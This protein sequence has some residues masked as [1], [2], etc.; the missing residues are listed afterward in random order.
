MGFFVA[1]LDQAIATVYKRRDATGLDP[2]TCSKSL[3]GHGTEQGSR[4]VGCRV[5]PKQA[6]QP[7]ASDTRDF[8][9]EYFAQKVLQCQS[10]GTLLATCSTGFPPR[11]PPEINLRWPGGPARGVG[12]P[13]SPPSSLLFWLFLRRID[14]AV[15]HF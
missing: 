9:V 2:L 12:G 15:S 3:G 7:A 11:N 10:L 14:L 1:W 6:L 13:L 4:C 5:E 8:Q